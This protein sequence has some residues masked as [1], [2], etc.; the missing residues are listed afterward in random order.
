MVGTSFDECKTDRWKHKVANM[1]LLLSQPSMNIDVC[2]GRLEF[3][4]WCK[5]LSQ[6]PSTVDTQYLSYFQIALS[7]LPGFYTDDYQMSLRHF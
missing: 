1:K 7:S 6:L 4:N 3:G 5:P 2:C